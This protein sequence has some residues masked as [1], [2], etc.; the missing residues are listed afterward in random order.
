MSDE[1]SIWVALGSMG[2]GFTTVLAYHGAWSERR[3]IIAVRRFVQTW[4]AKKTQPA[5]EATP[6]WLPLTV[7]ALLCGLVA[8][9]G[10]VPEGFERILPDFYHY[11]MIGVLLMVRDIGILY[12]LSL[13]KNP[14]SSGSTTVVYL[15]MLYLLIPTLLKL[16]GLDILAQLVCPI[17]PGDSMIGIAAA[18]G[19]CVFIAMLFKQRLHDL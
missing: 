12:Y 2:A 17:F 10:I 11:P 4:S 16:A 6:Y 9:T 19:H 18:V 3:D 1:T 8:T 5:L 14:Q 7:Y 15:L 13:G